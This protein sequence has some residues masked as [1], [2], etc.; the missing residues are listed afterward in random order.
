MDEVRITPS[1]QYSKSSHFAAVRERADAA[2]LRIAHRTKMGVRTLRIRMFEDDDPVHP[3]AV[4]HL[5]SDA[6]YNA[7]I[8][9]HVAVIDYGVRKR[10]IFKAAAVEVPIFRPLQQPVNTQFV[11][12]M[13]FETRTSP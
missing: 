1:R 2:R 9:R 7:L 8:Q 6:G 3:S 4:H 12:V 13:F 10:D 5:D 11:I